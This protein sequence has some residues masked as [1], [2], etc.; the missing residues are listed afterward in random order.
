MSS[1][2]GRRGHAGQ[3][4]GGAQS[5]GGPVRRRGLAVGGG[6]KPV[7]TGAGRLGTGQK[8]RFRHWVFTLNNWTEAERGRLRAVVP[9]D[10]QYLCFQPERGLLDGTPHLQGVVSFK[11]PKNLTSVKRIIGDRA[12][13]EQMRGTADHA[14]AYCC[15]AE[16]ADR[17]DPSYAFE[18]FGQ[19]PRPGTGTPGARS[20]LME[21]AQEILRGADSRTI[22]L[23]HPT[24][25]LQHD[26]AIERAIIMLQ[27]P[28]N[29]VTEVFWYHGPTGSG[30][31]RAVFDE[32]AA[33]DVYVKN[34]GNEWWCGYRGQPVV[35]LDDWRPDFCKFSA[36]LLLFDRYPLQLNRKN[37]QV[38]FIARRIYVTT[39]QSHLH[40]WTNVTGEKLNQL[41]RRITKEVPFKTG[42][43]QPRI[44]HD[45]GEFSTIP[46][47]LCPGGSRDE[48]L[49]SQDVTCR[50]D[51]SS[52]SD[53]ELCGEAESEEEVEE[54]T[55]A[56]PFARNF[57]PL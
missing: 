52:D 22:L 34:V 18:E 26:Q 47:D 7:S 17:S 32:N 25:W 5:P 8:N 11:D 30:K 1:K 12:H 51:E 53:S 23:K 10:G 55:A 40:S 31:T 38:N 36:L 45:W 2:R 44:R 4:D 29:W 15:K 6:I 42:V 48:E 54:T 37:G 21:V 20:D 13:L 27:A 16:S 19:R 57:N 28:R 24:V 39:P 49:L 43:Y 50:S 46:P 9:G 14:I 35:L 56:R 3:V 41:T 33:E